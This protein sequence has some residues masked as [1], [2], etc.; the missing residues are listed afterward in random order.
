VYA[1]ALL[2]VPPVLVLAMGW[3]NEETYICQST[4]FLMWNELTSKKYRVPAL[5]AFSPGSLQ[6]SGHLMIVQRPKTLPN[7][8]ESLT[9][10][11]RT[12]FAVKVDLCFTVKVDM[13]FTVKV[14]ICHCKSRHVFHCK[15]RHVFHCKSRHVFRCKSRHVFHCKT[16][17]VFHCF[18]AAKPWWYL[19][20]IN[21][22]HCTKRKW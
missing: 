16:R 10:V 19:V 6:F 17:H 11:S 13:C 7:R 3:N 22:M 12:Q 15:S 1:C 18:T 14:D 5:V 2:H 8:R 21:K 20:G 4:E 9:D